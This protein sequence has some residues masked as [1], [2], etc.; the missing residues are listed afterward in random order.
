MSRH[1]WEEWLLWSLKGWK[2]THDSWPLTIGSDP[3]IGLVLKLS[4]DII[5]NFFEVVAFP[6]LGKGEIEIE[7]SASTETLSRTCTM[8]FSRWE[9]TC[10]GPHTQLTCPRDGSQSV[11]VSGLPKWRVI[12]NG[13]GSMFPGV[14]HMAEHTSCAEL[15]TD[16]NFTCPCKARPSPVPINMPGWI[17]AGQGWV[18]NW[19]C[20][21]PLFWCLEWASLS[22]TS[23]GSQ[24]QCPGYCPSCSLGP[25]R[26]SVIQRERLRAL[27]RRVNQASIS[28]MPRKNKGNKE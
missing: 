13:I 25:C 6:Y 16:T 22:V 20:P 27:G 17:L 15:G 9:N 7:N 24:V 11:W 19:L 18:R 2:M 12:Q 8:C 5:L 21:S 14:S 3:D 23:T 10:A 26:I 28:A 4:P 1:E